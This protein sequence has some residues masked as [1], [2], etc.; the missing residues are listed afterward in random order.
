MLEAPFEVQFTTM[1]IGQIRVG[2]VELVVQLAK[3]FSQQHHFIALEVTVLLVLISES[4][5]H[6]LAGQFSERSRDVAVD[7]QRDDCGDQTEQCEGSNRRPNG[8]HLD[9]L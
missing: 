7:H 6:Y 3:L 5:T 1:L 2:P 4:E 8:S 9:V